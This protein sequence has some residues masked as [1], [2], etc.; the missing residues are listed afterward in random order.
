VTHPKN[1]LANARRDSSQYSPLPLHARTLPISKY[2]WDQS[3]KFVSVY[4]DFS[5]IGSFP[6]E[7]VETRFEET[8]FALSVTPPDR[9]ERHELVV[10]SLCWETDPAKC[11]ITLKADRF[12]VKLKKGEIGKEWDAL[13]DTGRKRKEERDKRVQHGDLKGA[14]TAALIQDMYENA[15]D[16][17]KQKLREAMAKGEKARADR[18]EK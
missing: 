13:D 12:V 9:G 15:D 1:L 18:G 2:A 10:P 6:G 7:A 3:D 16:E 8:T 14:S 11:K 17:Q 4:V 5:G